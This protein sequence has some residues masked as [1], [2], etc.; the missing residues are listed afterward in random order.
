MITQV[1]REQNVRVEASGPL[2]RLPLPNAREQVVLVDMQTVEVESEARAHLGAWVR[3]GGTLVVLGAAPDE[4]MS[5]TGPTLASSTEVDVGGEKGTIST[6]E[7]LRLGFGCIPLATVG[8][9]TTY[10]M[11]CSIGAGLVL[12]VATDDLFANIGFIR[13][14]NAKL[15]LELL[16]HVTHTHLL[17]ASPVD[18]VSLPQSP[19]ASLQRAGL[20]AG[21]WHALFVT[22]LF[23]WAVGARLGRPKPTAPPARRAFSE[24]VE[25]TGA[26][27]A[28]ARAGKHALASLVRFTEERF[29][30]DVASQLAHKSGVPHADCEAIWTRAKKPA[31][32]EEI[33]VMRELHRVLERTRTV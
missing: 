22:L 6:P 26:L 11:M 12:A 30:G 24:H 1:L 14:N 25:A 4:I 16:A 8:A 23:F 10:A 20:A 9:T 13:G 29:R 3:S 28:R 27:Y 15:A 32:G 2:V 33:A 21:L 5:D 17:V 18:G 31:K 19:L 7:G